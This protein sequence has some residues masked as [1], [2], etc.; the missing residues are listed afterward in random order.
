[1]N[2]I[3]P[4]I[5]QPAFS[6]YSIIVSIHSPC[7]VLTFAWLPP[8]GP[9]ILQRTCQVRHNVYFCIKASRNAV[10]PSKLLRSSHWKAHAGKPNRVPVQQRDLVMYLEQLRSRDFCDSKQS[11]HNTTSTG[12]VVRLQWK[13]SAIY[14][15]SRC[16][17]F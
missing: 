1:M 8:K 12:C 11:F 6:Q 17:E 16:P 9:I 13:C 10:W 5:V 3:K 15:R 7:I 4:C 14:G 2:C